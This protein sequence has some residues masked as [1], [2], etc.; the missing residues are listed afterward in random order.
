MHAAQSGDNIVDRQAS[1]SPNSNIVSSHRLAD[2]IRRQQKPAHH[3]IIDLV[4]LQSDMIFEIGVPK[5]QQTQRR[6]QGAATAQ[7][8]CKRTY[9]FFS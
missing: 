2:I 9:H 8:I 1:T 4:V 3:P 7:K 5:Y 6:A